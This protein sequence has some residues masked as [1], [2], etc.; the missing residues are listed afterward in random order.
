MET[1]LVADRCR[2]SIR[3][4]KPGEIPY[5]DL[6]A[7]SFHLPLLGKLHAKFM[8]VDR[9]IAVVESNNMEDND[10]LEMMTLVDG[11]IVDSIYDTALIT[12]GNAFHTSLPSAKA[13]AREGGLGTTE[14][15]KEPIYVD[16]G[17][18]REQDQ[19]ITEGQAAS[20][21]ENMPGDPRYD[22]DLASEITRMQSAYS[23]KADESLLQAANRQLNLLCKKPSPPTG[24]AIAPGE[25]LPH[26]LP[27]PHPAQCPSRSSL[28][29]LSGNP[30]I[31]A[32]S[33]PR[34]KPGSLASG[35]RNSPS[36]SKHPTST[37]R[38]STTPSSKL[39]NK[40]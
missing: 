14:P 10:N 16:R 23:A 36:L 24:P 40:A 38:L 25:E 26:T 9:K 28:A 37:R 32:S 11:P 35:T 5:L 34:M 3:L 12:W 22:P 2:K 17:V 33:C 21:P 15:G 27:Y 29:H 4:P 7:I 1:L 13:T 6:E 19:I 18:A 20:P 31:A 8:V 39:S 30:R